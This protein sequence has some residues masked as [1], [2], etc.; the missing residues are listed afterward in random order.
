[1]LLHLAALG[2]IIDSP[3]RLGFTMLQR[4]MAFQRLRIVHGLG[5]FASLGVTIGLGLAGGGAYAIV[6]GN[7]VVAALPFTVYL[8]LVR[9]WRPQPGWWRW[10]DWKA[11][12]PALRFGLQQAGSGLLYAA[13]GTLEATVLPVAL[14]YTSIGL[15]NRA[16]ALFSI[17]V[18]R[19]VSI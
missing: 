10:P 19:V 12:R 16:Q 6:L 18:G 7:N 14:G 17:T 8:L 11:Y 9:R 5:M 2:L 1:P 13:R 3:N 15:L 4:A